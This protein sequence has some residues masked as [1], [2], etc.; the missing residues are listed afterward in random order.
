MDALSALVDTY[1]SQL[2]FVVTGPDDMPEINDLVTRIRSEATTTI[3]DDDVLL[4]P[5]G[6]TNE[7]LAETRELTADLAM[8]HGYRYTPRLH[9][10][11]W[12]D[13]PGR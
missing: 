3:T 5:E 12:E 4:M 9:V 7:Q 8:E 1:P 2:K 11:L 6:V 13:A 10:N